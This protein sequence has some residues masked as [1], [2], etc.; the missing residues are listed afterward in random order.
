MSFLDVVCPIKNAFPPRIS[1]FSN[2]NQNIIQN[3]VDS[4][5]NMKK[6]IDWPQL[7]QLLGSCPGW[8][9]KSHSVFVTNEPHRGKYFSR[10]TPQGPGRRGPRRSPVA[11][12]LK[13][14]PVN[15]F[16]EKSGAMTAI[17]SGC[18]RTFLWPA[19]LPQR[20]GRR[21]PGPALPGWSSG[22]N[23]R[24]S[25]PSTSTRKPCCKPSRSGG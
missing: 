16:E 22:G 15:F 12:R 7:F 2:P 21:R 11:R 9:S 25:C 23:S 14:G 1:T 18:R 3:V 20:C 5:S 6:F 17:G 10:P 24:P 19:A 13:A 4:F 8:W